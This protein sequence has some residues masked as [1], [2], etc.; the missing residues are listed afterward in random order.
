MVFVFDIELVKFL[1]T[2]FGEDSFS[3]A[4]GFRRCW[5]LSVLLLLLLLLWTELEGSWLIIETINAF[6]VENRINNAN[7]L[8]SPLPAEG[9]T[10]CPKLKTTLLSCWKAR[11]HWKGYK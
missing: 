4:K 5:L 8:P 2:D 9:V 7:D 11:K 1:R 3:K 6:S 10:K